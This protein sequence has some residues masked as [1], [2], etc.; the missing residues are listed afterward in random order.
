MHGDERQGPLGGRTDPEPTENK[1]MNHN[2]TRAALMG[3]MMVAGVLAFA[4]SANATPVANA[5][6]SLGNKEQCDPNTVVSTHCYY[7]PDYKREECV[8]HPDDWVN[9]A[10]MIAGQCIATEVFDTMNW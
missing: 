2:P 5:E 4:G 9:C 8:K 10:Y 7:C 6:T 3:L 1:N